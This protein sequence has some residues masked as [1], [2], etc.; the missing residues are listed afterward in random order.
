MCKLA[1][2]TQTH[3]NNNNNINNHKLRL[4]LSKDSE[5]E[6]I[7]TITRKKRRSLLKTTTDKL[8]KLSLKR[9]NTIT[10]TKTKAGEKFYDMLF[11]GLV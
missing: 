10:I 4:L 11:F 3:I 2:A 1:K 5:E 9:R 7:I 6:T 8:K